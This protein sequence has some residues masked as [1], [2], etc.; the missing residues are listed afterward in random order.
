[1]IQG[2]GKSPCA[3][4]ELNKVMCPHRASGPQTGE[5]AAEASVRT[6]RP[7]SWTHGP[8]GQQLSHTVGGGTLGNTLDCVLL[9]H[10]RLFEMGVKSER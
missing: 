1:M 2:V 9:G 6:M 10:K 7:E 8:T 5:V 4:Q 3:G